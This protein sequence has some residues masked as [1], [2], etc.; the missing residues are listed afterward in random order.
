MINTSVWISIVIVLF[1]VKYVFIVPYRDNRLY[2]MYAARD[3]VALMA[4]RNKISQDSEE[5]EFVMDKMCFEIYYSKYEYNFK[6]IFD[7]L[8][9]NSIR[10]KDEFDRMIK[11]VEENEPLKVAFVTAYDEFISRLNWRL[12]AFTYFV[13]YPF[14]LIINIVLWILEF[15]LKFLKFQSKIVDKVG[16]AA[17]QTEFVI[18][19]CRD[20]LRQNPYRI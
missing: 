3:N 13:L 7:N 4:T 20:Y 15:I 14:R 2:K 18:S 8:F 5:Y 6:I 10:K 16:K 1:I 12:K 11:K 9:K 19:N 17:D